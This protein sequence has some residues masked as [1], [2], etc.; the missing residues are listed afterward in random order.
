MTAALA[1]VENREV[2]QHVGIFGKNLIDRW[3]KFAGVGKAS[4]VTYS[5]S[6]RQLFKYFQSKNITAPT[7]D[8]LV[9]W[10][11]GM[12]AA[13]D[14]EKMSASTVVLYVMATKLFF[15]WLAQENLY[16]NIADNL[17]AAHK[18]DNT[19]KKDALDTEQ[20]KTLVANVK[21]ISKKRGKRNAIMELRDKAILSLMVTAGL[22]TIEVVRANVGDIR[23]ERGKIFLL[24]KGKG[25]SSSNEKILISKQTYAAIRRYLNARGKCEASEPLFTST[26]VNH[27][28]DRLQTQSISRMVK[29]NLR[30]MELDSPRLTA[31]SLRHSAAT[32][33]VFAH[34]ELPKVQ[35]VLRHRSISTTQIY[36][37]AYDRFTNDSEQVIADIIFGGE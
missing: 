30:G 13:V 26:S 1:N 23:F 37:D 10:V 24:V 5:K 12:D 20:C 33:M 7:R 3:V 31:H 11:A 25:R 35:K 16:P 32:N 34:I 14:E 27:K 28:G 29:A 22:R 19:F 6:L 8:N 18:P 21:C 2:N 4:I 17:K 15:R 9:E 36:V